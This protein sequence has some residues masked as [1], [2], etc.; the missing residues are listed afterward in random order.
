MHY[1]RLGISYKHS[2]SVE[3]HVPVNFQLSCSACV[4]SFVKIQEIARG[5]IYV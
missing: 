4:I 2:V 5:T 1:P 3:D